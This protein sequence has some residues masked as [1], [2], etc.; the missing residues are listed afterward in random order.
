MLRHDVTT[1]PSGLLKGTS[2]CSFVR[3]VL[4]SAKQGQPAA[5]TPLIGIYV[6][7]NCL[8][9]VV[10]ALLLLLLHLL[11]LLFLTSPSLPRS[12]T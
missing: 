7:C 9:M 2:K 5:S 12:S 6:P 11:L 4:L 10:N 8:D 1:S 3:L